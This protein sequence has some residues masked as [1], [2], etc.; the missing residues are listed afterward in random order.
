LRILVFFLV[1]LVLAAGP[2]GA[3]ILP[4]L[5][6]GSFVYTGWVFGSSAFGSGRF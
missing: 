2:A 4:L 3:V 6:N 1:V 5:T